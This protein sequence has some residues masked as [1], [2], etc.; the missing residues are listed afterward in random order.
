MKKEAPLVS[1]FPFIVP[2]N[3]SK[4]YSLAKE[5][6]NKMYSYKNN[7]MFWRN[8]KTNLLLMSCIH[9]FTLVN[10]HDNFILVCEKNLCMYQKLFHLNTPNMRWPQLSLTILF[11]RQTLREIAM[12]LK[13]CALN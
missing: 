10:S 7:V 4:L 9:S 1:S 2:Q 12:T 13:P 6:K 5:N 11:V 3:A 8:K